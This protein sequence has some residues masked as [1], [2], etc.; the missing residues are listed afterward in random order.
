MAYENCPF[1][2]TPYD[3]SNL[4]KVPNLV[5][6]NYTNQDFWSLKNKLVEFINELPK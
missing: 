1:D 6:L 5:N 2:I 3:Q 4:V